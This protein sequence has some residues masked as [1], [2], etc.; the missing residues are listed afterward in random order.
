MPSKE[1]RILVVM[2][3]SD[4][5]ILFADLISRRAGL[6]LRPEDSEKYLK[7]IGPRLR[8]RKLSTVEE[9][10]GF[11]TSDTTE[12][13]SEWEVVTALLTTGETYFFRDR[14]QFALIKNWILPEVIA[15]RRDKKCL[16]IWSAG[17]ATGEEPYSMAILVKELLPECKGWDILIIGTDINVN[18]IAKA[19]K[20]IY[21]QWSFRLVDP[22]VQGRYFH[23]R[24]DEWELDATIKEMVRFQAGNL[25][26]E[27]F[28]DH[29]SGLYDMDLILCR[30]VFIYFSDE[31]VSVAVKKLTDTLAEGGSLITGHGEL[32]GRRLERLQSVIFPES[33][34]YQ[35]R[36]SEA[37]VERFEGGKS[38]KHEKIQDKIPK[39]LPGVT[40]IP[41]PQPEVKAIELRTQPAELQTLLD[42]AESCANLGEY[43]KAAALCKKAID[44]DATAVRPYFL[45]A[46]LVEAKGDIEKAKGLLKKAIY[47]DPAFS[48]AYLELGALY[49][50]EDDPERAKTM[51]RTALTLLQALPPEAAIEPYQG[52]TAGELVRYVKKLTGME[53][54]V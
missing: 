38:A 4:T 20:G 16:R 14:G 28:P 31:A 2:A 39:P 13:N 25:I 51:R 32:H 22:D 3:M 1:N 5:G 17:C 24:K 43:D 11:L 12:S 18:A 44:S 29:A 10:C 53:V 46:H 21:T 36:S 19:Q 9:Y 49:E 45:M 35:K 47:L 7:A 37:G 23:R 30:N 42:A 6:R 52:V 27:P 54:M 15:R 40:K 26:Q 41:I 50:N 8:Q 34:I 33:V 48:P